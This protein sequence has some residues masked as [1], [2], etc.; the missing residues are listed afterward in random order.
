[1]S[2]RAFEITEEDV[3]NAL[4]SNCLDVANSDGK[5]FEEMAT[6]LMPLLNLPNVEGAALYGKTLEEQTAYAHNEIVLQLRDLGVLEQP[7]CEEVQP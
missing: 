5:T 3:C 7:R 6:E 1:M 2:Q 4:S